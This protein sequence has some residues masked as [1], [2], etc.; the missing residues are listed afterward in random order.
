MGERLQFRPERK[1]LPFGAA[2]LAAVLTVAIFFLLPSLETL[3]ENKGERLELR[4]VDT[5]ALAPP[6]PTVEPPRPPPQKRERRETPKP[7]LRRQAR[8]IP[9][10]AML[11][12]DFGL[13]AA[14]GDFGLDFDITAGAGGAIGKSV[15]SLDEIDQN[16]ISIV[17]N[18]PIY[19]IRA[20]MR[21]IEGKVVLQFV[22]DE[23]G[24]VRGL[25]VVESTPR[26]IFES[27]A[28][29]AVER[30]RFKPGIKD[31]RT[32]AVRVQQKLKFRLDR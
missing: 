12:I 29:R 20:K 5:L 11:D 31:G 8:P 2:L 17:K 18:P 19:P 23:N 27:A 24:A 10:N 32:V 4:S 26:G 25:S 6:P 9:L 3:R 16:P 7:E 13:D 14:G 15:F 30:W 28:R 1:R 21:R 22:V